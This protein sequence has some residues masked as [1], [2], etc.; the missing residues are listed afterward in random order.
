MMTDSFRASIDGKL[1]E[2]QNLKEEIA[3]LKQ[4]LE[5]KNAHIEKCETDLDS[6]TVSA[7]K[8]LPI[9]VYPCKYIPSVFFVSQIYCSSTPANKFIRPSS[10]HS[11]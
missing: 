5:E 3:A 9:E 7:Y 6:K 2:V 11:Y 1:E 4:S 10:I 8:T